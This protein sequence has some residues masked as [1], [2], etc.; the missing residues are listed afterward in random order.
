MSDKSGSSRSRR[1]MISS[2]L[3]RRLARV[4]ELIKGSTP[5]DEIGNDVD[6]D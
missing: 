4:R 3:S 6:M 5:S 2:A 1:F